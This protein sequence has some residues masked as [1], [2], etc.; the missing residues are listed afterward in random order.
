MSFNNFDIEANGF[1]IYFK[2]EKNINIRGL[3]RIDFNNFR[4]K[5][6]QGIVFCGNEKISFNKIRLNNIDAEVAVQNPLQIEFTDNLKMN[7]VDL[8]K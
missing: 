5:S 1:A 4:I 8:S 7:C 3:N 2:C 6:H